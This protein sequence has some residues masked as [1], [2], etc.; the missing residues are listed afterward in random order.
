MEF[1]PELSGGSFGGTRLP[2]HFLNLQR[3]QH[4]SCRGPCLPTTRVGRSSA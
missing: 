2:A 4:H 1:T 3:A